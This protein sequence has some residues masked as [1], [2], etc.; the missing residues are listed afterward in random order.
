MRHCSIPY[1]CLLLGFNATG[2]AVGQECSLPR[3]KIC[4]LHLHPE[5]LKPLEFKSR[6]GSLLR[7]HRGLQMG[8]LRLV[9]EYH[10]LFQDFPC[11]VTQAIHD[12]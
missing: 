12:P 8:V 5:A 3:V 7:H 10:Q 2:R 11:G 1:S 6:F 9:I 4:P